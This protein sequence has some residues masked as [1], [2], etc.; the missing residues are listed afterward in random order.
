MHS[1]E[2]HLNAIVNEV[3]AQCTLRAFARF[4]NGRPPLHVEHMALHM[5]PTPQVV[6]D[7]PADPFVVM[8]TS[9]TQKSPQVDAILGLSAREV[10]SA[11]GQPALEVIVDTVQGA[12]T[13][14]TTIGPYDGDMQRFQGRGMRKSVDSV[15]K[16]I[17]EKLVGKDLDQTG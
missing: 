3:T 6:K 7:Q 5:P 14:M 4:R 15:E 12:F 2:L 13:A 1:L 8:S 16:L 17:A 10:L 9:L 11:T